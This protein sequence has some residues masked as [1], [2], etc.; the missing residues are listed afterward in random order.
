MSLDKKSMKL[1]VSVSAMCC[2]LAGCDAFAPTHQM[3]DFS[4]LNVKETKQTTFFPTNDEFVLTKEL[5]IEIIKKLKD[6]Y[7]KGLDNIRFMLIANKS[8]SID[9]EKKAKEKISFIMKKNGL[10]DSRIMYDDICIYKDAKVGIKIDILKYDVEMPDCS[11]WN[12]SIGDM[13][14]TK[15]LPK[16]GYAENY[17][18]AAMVANSADIVSPR[19]YKGHEPK[20]AISSMG[21]SGGAKK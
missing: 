18:M 21:A 11:P 12:S 1:I 17:N 4:K 15:N 7:A 3:E 6:A 5:E 8:I 13:D 2:M 16:I 10:I 9:V 19:T 14:V 20:D